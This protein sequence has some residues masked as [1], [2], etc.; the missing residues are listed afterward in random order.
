A[1]F[2]VLDMG[3]H[4]LQ[5]GPF[6]ELAEPA[7]LHEGEKVALQRQISEV[8]LRLHDPWKGAEK[9]LFPRGEGPV[10]FGHA[11]V[12]RAL[13]DGE[14]SDLRRDFRHE[15]DGAGAI[16][17]D[18]DALAREVHVMVP[19]RRVEGYTLEIAEPFD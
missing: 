3:F 13:E 2:R 11:P 14:L 1:E 15:L 6:E 19:A 12:G 9:R 5:G 18:A 17:D 10:G 4:F 8:A 16:S 7:A